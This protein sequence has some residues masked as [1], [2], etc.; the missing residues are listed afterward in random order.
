MN[1]VLQD[2]SVGNDPWTVSFLFYAVSDIHLFH[3]TL[4]VAHM[5]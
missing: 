3:F 1:H 5:D 2:L 4:A